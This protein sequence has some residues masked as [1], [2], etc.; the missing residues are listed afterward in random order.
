MD[1]NMELIPVN[2]KS[3]VQVAQLSQPMM[4]VAEMAAMKF[5]QAEAAMS[6]ELDRILALS[7]EQP[8]DAL[9]QVLD[10]MQGINLELLK[11]YGPVLLEQAQLRSGEFLTTGKVE[12]PRKGGHYMLVGFLKTQEAAVKLGLASTRVRD[13]LSRRRRS[14]PMA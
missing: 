5:P 2:M 4:P 9:A 14:A 8:L 10:L 7:R 3:E 6:L 13:E 1:T 12:E 11:N